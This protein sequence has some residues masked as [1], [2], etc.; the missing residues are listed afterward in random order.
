MTILTT[1]RLTLRPFADEHLAGLHAMN[2]EPEVMRFITGRPE[3]LDETRASIE[4]VKAKWIEWGYSWWAIFEHDSNDIIGA[5]CIQHL[6]RDAGLPMEL[7][8]RLRPEYWGKGYA[9]EAARA[10]AQFAFDT[11]GTPE[12]VAVCHQDN[13]ASAQ[14][15]R[16][17]GMSYRGIERWY[18]TETT[19]YV[20]SRAGWQA[21]VAARL[22]QAGSAR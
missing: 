5:G 7:G 9:S 3:T 17:L 20:I 15:M 11:T 6:Q 22:S 18:D 4:R 21:A 19:V 2:R 1:A 12:L 16:R 13:M 10:M 14:V 8:W